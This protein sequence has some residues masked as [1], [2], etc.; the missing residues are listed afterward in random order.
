MHPFHIFISAFNLLCA[1]ALA[2]FAWTDIA[3][4]GAFAVIGGY[5]A[6]LLAALTSLVVAI[7]YLVSLAK[8]NGRKIVAGHWLGLF[9][10]AFV[11]AFWTAFFNWSHIAAIFN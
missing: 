7:W 5:L 11:V 6:N 10:G 2:A 4:L 8:G 1:A 9:N 3:A